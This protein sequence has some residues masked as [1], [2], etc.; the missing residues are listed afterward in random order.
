M[1]TFSKN[2]LD[3]TRPR[4]GS[5]VSFVSLKWCVCCVD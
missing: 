5:S 2:F 3:R 4:C 1:K